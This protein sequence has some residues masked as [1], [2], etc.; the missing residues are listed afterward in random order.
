MMR[1]GGE[2]GDGQ[3]EAGL[4]NSKERQPSW[5]GEVSLG[6][7]EL[8]RKRA[9]GGRFMGS[10]Q[11]QIL[12]QGHWSVVAHDLHRWGHGSSDCFG[13][14]KIQ[15]FPSSTRFPGP[16]HRAVGSK[17]SRPWVKCASIQ[18]FLDL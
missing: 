6:K 14:G 17:R 18:R 10:R 7:E 1:L 11:P 13:T 16:E 15:S 12:K 3:N 2:R 8:G 5:V 4:G 9:Y